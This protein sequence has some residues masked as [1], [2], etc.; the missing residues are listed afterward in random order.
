MGRSMIF[1]RNGA[2]GVREV[3][4]ERTDRADPAENRYKVTSD[5]CRSLGFIPGN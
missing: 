5:K 2:L 3:G 1:G 4:A